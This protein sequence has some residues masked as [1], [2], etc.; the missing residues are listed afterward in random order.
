MFFA[1]PARPRV[2]VLTDFPPLDVIPGG[3]GSGPPERRSDPD[4]VQSMVRLLLHSNDLEIVGLV[5]SAGTFANVANKKNLLDMLDR[6]AQV[7][8]N[9]RRHDRRYPTAKYLR[10]ITWQGASGTYGRP[11]S[12]LL[13]P[14]KA[15]EASAQIVRLLESPDP[16]LLWFCVWG[17][18]CELAQAI[19]KIQQ[20][21]S[22]KETRRMLA[23]VRV[24]LIGLQ[25]GTGQW[26][27]DTFPNLRILL[28]KGNYM[29]MFQNARGADATIA[30]LGWVEKN[31]RNG[32]GP[33]GAAYPRSGFY[34]DSPGVWEGDSPS[35]LYLV[36][37][38]RGVSDA[39]RPDRPSWGGQFVR[40]DPARDHWV[41]HPAGAEA[42]W[43][44]RADVQA[45]FAKRLDWCVEPRRV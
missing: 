26:L 5:A 21:R 29:G 17:G 34:P 37:A 12:E 28:S 30:D 22:P 39:E 19:L 9:L 31:V 36:S 8:R 32:H 1:A 24:Y 11:A 44:W 45:E 20:T 3:V 42:V 16:R 27:L 23:K 2:V 38:A 10:S 6:Y 41:D 13:V 15:S 40:P 4:D 33:L 18:S 14:G 25:D 35:F 7:E 43:R